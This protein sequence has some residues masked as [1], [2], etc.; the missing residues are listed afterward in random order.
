L[1]VVIAIIGVLVALLLPAVQSAREAARRMSCVNNLR[2]T[3]IALHN[4]H[5]VFGTFPPGGVTNG[6]CCGTQSGPTWTIFILP[7]I[8]QQALFDRYDQTQTN[9]SV[10]NAFARTQFVKLPLSERC[11]DEA[12]DDSHERPRQRPECEYATGSCLARLA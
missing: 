9:E 10:A 6:P 4:H 8:E 1:L 3:G 2:Q 5:D 12:A 7:Y 11:A